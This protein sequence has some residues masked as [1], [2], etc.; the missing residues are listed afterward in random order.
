MSGKRIARSSFRVAAS[1][2]TVLALTLVSACAGSDAATTGEAEKA[3]LPV[4]K[5]QGKPIVIGMI[6]NDSNAAGNFANVGQATRAA[7]KYINNNLGGAGGRPIRLEYC[8]SNGT[9][10]A[11]A[12]CAAQLLQEKPATVIGGLDLG[13]DGSIPVLAKAGVP[14]LSPT[15]TSSAD[16]T[17]PT[18]FSFVAG[19]APSQGAA[20]TYAAKE[21]KTKKAAVLFNENPQARLTAE[22]FV[23]NVLKAHGVSHVTM[24]PFSA[25]ETDMAGPLSHALKGGTDTVF[26]IMPEAGCVNVLKAKQSLASTA[27]YF[28][29]GNCAAPSVLK[30]GGSAAEGTY[31]PVSVQPANADTP[32]T[33]AFRSA[34]ARYAP[35]VDL[36]VYPESAFGTAVTLSRVLAKID[37]PDDPSAVMSAL[38]G[39]KNQPTFVGPK[40]TCD[41]KQVK[42]LPSV[43][44][45]K[46]RI[47]KSENGELKDDAGRWYPE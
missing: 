18:S 40:V 11:S 44:S 46:V 1:A 29:S 13:S 22:K 45:D 27:N 25:N 36:G 5:A 14:Y 21:L 31:F 30:A 4:K 32:D 38:R 3:E 47:V 28:F 43:C 7:V 41:G 12:N 9:S 19:S 10:A 8:A 15:P 17:S 24:A 2:C 6:N 26:G 34:M 39:L 16:L 23:R 37:K 42:S 33:K 35:S 20:A